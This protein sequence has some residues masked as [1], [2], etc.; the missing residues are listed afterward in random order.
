MGDIQQD[1]FL[2]FSNWRINKSWKLIVGRDTRP[3]PPKISS[4]K[5]DITIA[6]DWYRNFLIP[7]G[8]A[9]SIP[10]FESLSVHK[11]QVDANPPIP[12][13]TDWKAIYR[14]FDNWV[15]EAEGLKNEERTKYYRQMMRH[16]VLISYNSGTRPAELLGRLDKRRVPHPEGGW[17]I[18]ET[19]IGGLR[20]ADV[21]VEPKTHHT[22]TGKSFEFLEAMLYIRESKTGVPREIPTNTGKYFL[23]WRQ[24]CDQ[25][26]KE[27]GLPK[28]YPKDYVFFN[29][30]T[31]RPYP[32]S[33]VSSSWDQMRVNLSLILNPSKSGNL[34]T[35]YS[36][37]SSYITNQINEGKDVYLIK[38]LTGHSLEVLNKHYD[39]S[40]VR[41]R[42]DEATSRTY[43]ASKSK[44][45]KIDLN[46]A[47]KYKKHT[48]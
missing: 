40:E 27:N 31:G 26:R 9:T 28:L 41:R 45:N 38:K 2:D 37:R 24:F 6:K 47:D 39:R 30:F 44:S 25:F 18:Q 8:Y 4:I 14:Y 20:W 43:G 33:Q 1:T 16:F 35:L 32:Y 23:R 36:L 7:K 22:S 48:A 17:T 46:K 15:D 29:P 34:Y 13:E 3:A 12:L 42:R 19:I 5:R 10:S 21:E 11:D